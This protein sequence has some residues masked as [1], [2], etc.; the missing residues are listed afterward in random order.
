VI[1]ADGTTN[2]Y[3]L[4]V[5]S[6]LQRNRRVIDHGGESVGFLS[7][8]TVYPDSRAAI[9]VFTNA[10]FSGATDALTEG[11]E[12][13][14]L[15]GGQPSVVAEADRLED[16]R[17][18]YQAIVGGTVDRAKFTDNLNYYFDATALGDYRASLA[19]LGMPKIE[20]TRG[21]RL[22]GGFV[23]RNFKLVYPD[24][25]LTL[26]TYAEPGPSGRWEQFLIMPE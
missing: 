10:D 23:N 25:S 12:N 3:G 20:A 7:Q 18:V 6:H 16:V 9:V 24:R 21:P 15:A 2:G 19:P 22:R 13:I 8:N 5:S 11:I 17:A 26:V 4:G 1:L 14:V